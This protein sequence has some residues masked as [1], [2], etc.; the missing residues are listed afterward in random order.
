MVSIEKIKARIA[1]VIDRE[2]AI[3]QKE[4]AEFEEKIY[5]NEQFYGLGG[6]HTQFSKA[7]ERRENHIEELEA[8]KKA[9]GGSVILDDLKLY[10]FYCPSCQ[11]TVYLDDSAVKNYRENTIDCPLCT[12]PIYRSGQY[13][14]WKIQRGSRY[15]RL[16][17]E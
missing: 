13:V 12:R 17:S 8:L 3:A 11:R 1:A 5:G 2:I 6:W 16:H 14:V 10:P 9:Q 15:V 4:I 7:K